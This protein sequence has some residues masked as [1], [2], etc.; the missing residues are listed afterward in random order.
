MARASFDARTLV[1]A[2]ALAVAAALPVMTTSVD[3]RDYYFFDVALTSSSPGTTQVFWDIG[4]G[5]TEQDSSRQPLKIEPVPVVY[6]YMMPMGTIRELRFDPID[7]VGSFTL[8]DARV[9]DHKGRVV[10]AFAPEDFTPANEIARC[11]KQDA[12]LI[13]R[14]TDGSRDPV[15]LLKLKTPL[16]LKSS[17]RI[18]FQLGWPKAWPVFL[19]A[20]L[21]G[22]PAT[23]R[24]LFRWAQ[25]GAKWVQ[26]RPRC[27]IATAALLAVAIQSHPVIFQGRSF[28]SPNNGALMLYGD[29]PTLPGNADY[30]YANTMGSDV[31]ALIFNHLYYP[32]AQRRALFRDH[33][34]PLWNRYVLCGGPL[35]GQGQSMFGN[36]FTF[37]TMLADGEGWAWDAQFVVA[38]WLLAAGL[39]FIVW[40][41]TRHLGASLVVT[42]SAVFISF[43][44]HR[45]NHPA[46]FSV[47]YAPWILW[48]WVG[49]TQTKN[50]RG[51]TGWLLALLV[52]NA[53]VMT[54]GTIKEAYM[55]IV[56]LN[57]AGV[58]LLFFQPET[59]GR[60]GK[61]LAL[62]SG[63][64][65]IFILLSA[66][67][68][69]SFLVSWKHSF[70][71][72]DTPGAQSLP[73]AHA[74]GLFDDIFHRQASKDEIVKAPGLNFLFLLGALWWLVNP[75][76]WRADRAGA[77]IALACL[78]PLAFAFGIVPASI[79]V[80]IPFV[81]NVI[82]TGNTF[83]CVL[84]ILVAVLAGCGFAHAFRTI[85]E[86]R[87]WRSAVRTLALGAGMA[88]AF[89]LSTRGA[90]KSPFFEGYAPALAIGAISLLLAVGWAARD[91]A[92]RRGPIW[93]TLVIGV[94]LL[95]WRHCQF[96]ETYF[97]YY[98]FA[99]ANRGH[100][101]APSPSVAFV[102]REQPAH[103]RIAGWGNNLFP[104]YN[105][106]LDWESLYGVDALRNRYYT[107]LAVEFGMER[108]WFW[109]AYSDEKKSPQ[110]VPFQ[111]VLNVTHYVATKRDLPHPIAELEWLG[112]QDFDVYRSPKAWPRAFFT[113]R[114][115]SYQ[116]PKDFA[117]MVRAGDRRPFAAV[118]Q[119]DPSVPAFA[120]SS[121]EGRVVQP[122]TNLRLTSNNTSFAVEA[123]GPGVVV[124]T[125]AFYPDDFQ[126]TLNGQRVPF[127]RVNHAFK[128]ISIPAAGHY[129]ISFAYWPQHFE[130]AL[131]LG[132]VGLVLLLAGG[133]WL[134]RRDRHRELPL[135]QA[136]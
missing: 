55:L 73:L 60:R 125:E 36:P 90:P 50:S 76:F 91:G 101:H 81:A 54:S 102:D 38:R 7:G 117:S 19:V 106:A 95:L 99:P 89:F 15:L 108:V 3:R 28:A 51:E 43:F 66:P 63:A 12:V 79:V 65:A 92:P 21:L 119:G 104:A 88:V 42:G 135:V 71:G 41:L 87:W 56:C 13:V 74:I 110:L 6:R 105:I 116:T 118:Q 5:Y 26:G 132:G 45:L 70:S 115:A 35:L 23:T 4:R 57:L 133:G 123:S 85:H 69:M 121:L 29:L 52:A 49:L 59:V 120:A 122:A 113:D 114:L 39:G 126:V 32:M 34:L 129:E 37:L 72:Y 25:A 136:A 100:F 33:E 107:D 10:R 109:D 8:R 40:R 77:A 47:C 75:R 112:Q 16:V 82:H 14:T 20:M 11:E 31:G 84:L 18:W 22:A 44:T 62:A 86:D 130:T 30:M 64:G 94:P 53:T 103:G 67:G 27:A 68:W 78:L 128:G 127:F 46:N 1:V 96:D 17:P 58:L 2:L 134:Y 124:L 83:S 48:A 24:L 131:A 80:K 97:A 93:A 111:D 61:I 9:V 98:A